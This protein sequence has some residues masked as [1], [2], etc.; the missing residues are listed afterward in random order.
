MVSGFHNL[1]SVGVIKSFNSTM[2][3]QLALSK[4]SMVS[5][6]HSLPSV[7]VVRS[8]NGERLLQFTFT[9]RC[10]IIQWRANSTSLQVMLFSQIYTHIKLS[11]SYSLRL[12]KKW[13]Y[14]INRPPVSKIGASKYEHLWKCKKLKQ[15]QT[16]KSRVFHD[17]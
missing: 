9:R 14:M 17:S 11:H 2:Y 16:Q 7:G 10:Q 6:F 3:F 4:Y 12:K 13:Y 15:K 5:D 1:L 8:F